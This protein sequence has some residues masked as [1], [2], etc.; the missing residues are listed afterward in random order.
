LRCRFLG[1]RVPPELALGFDSRIPPLPPIAVEDEED[2]D[3]RP[4]FGLR[5]RRSNPIEDYSTT[6]VNPGDRLKSELNMEEKAVNV[7]RA[8]KMEKVIF[9]K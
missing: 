6:Y 7:R 9:I 4:R 3:D 8:A 5:R 1:S 2:E